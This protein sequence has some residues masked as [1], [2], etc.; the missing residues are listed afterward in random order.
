MGG[1]PGFS[2]SPA[3]RST[4]RTFGLNWIG[5]KE[6]SI[7]FLA[8]R[9]VYLIAENSLQKI[10]CWRFPFVIRGDCSHLKYE[11]GHPDQ[12]INNRIISRMNW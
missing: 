1:S 2:F 4:S 10:L 12:D 6:T 8:V 3:Y 11:S 5:F 9:Q 7:S